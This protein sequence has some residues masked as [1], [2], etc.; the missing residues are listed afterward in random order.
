M[1]LLSLDFDPV[2]GDDTTRSS[3]AAD[4]SVYDYD[5]VIWDPAASFHDYYS[6]YTEYYQNL[7]ALTD[8]ES[9]RIIADCKRRRNEFSE[10]V[11]SGKTLVVIVR[12]P[13]ECYVDTGKHTYSG[14]GRNRVTTRQVDRYDLW[15]A[16]P[17]PATLTKASGERIEMQAD[18][19]ITALLKQYQQH[20]SYEAVM[21]DVQ[22]T[23][24]AK[25]RGTERV[26]GSV[27]RSDGG[28]YIIMLPVVN[29]ASEADNE[30]G[31]EDGDWLPDA[32]QF[33]LDLLAAIEQLTDTA[34][35]SRPA[36]AE[37]YA[38]EDQEKLRGAVIEQQ[39]K[40]ESARAKLAKL[41][42]QKSDAEACDQLFLGTGRILENQVRDV[43]ELLGGQVT[44]PEPGR[45]DWKVAF[46]EGEAVVEVKGVSKSAAEKH[47]AQL[48]KWVASAYEETGTMPK[49]ILVVNTWRETPLTKRT[50]E[51]FP[52]QMLPY[53][54]GR[55]HCLVTGLQFFLMR[56]EVEKDQ[57]R[58]EHWRKTLLTT[59]GV[60]P[61]GDWRTVI[62][63][64]KSEK[65]PG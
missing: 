64:T 18:G 9:V 13:Q 23:A 62:R 65:V 12:P 49:G 14:T 44:E 60:I 40:V 29:L 26:V 47:A 63:E 11:K 61:T 46:P 19:P 32:P 2:Y 3:F 59:S 37:D 36:W 8:H 58:A 16:L 21:T 24:V 20:L 38:T 10:F 41:Q 22:G 50:K 6:Q 42:Q 5:V 7:P 56:A 57:S 33:Q 35:A 43:L 48:E 27:L 30:T 1:K 55:G 39:T 17:I 31:D 52:A 34:G 53:S 28:G 51:D 25:V 15:R 54:E 45:D 4:T